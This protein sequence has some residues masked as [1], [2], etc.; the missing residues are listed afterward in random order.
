MR[1]RNMPRRVL[2]LTLV[3]VLA[4]GVVA[5]G[6]FA[7]RILSEAWSAEAAEDRMNEIRGKLHEIEKRNG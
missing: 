3:L 4:L 1:T 5:P 6:A 2:A 7:I